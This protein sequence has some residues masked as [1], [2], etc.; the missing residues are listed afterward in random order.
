MGF[1][2]TD[3]P[4]A[5]LP[6]GVGLRRATALGHLIDWRQTTAP[7]ATWGFWLNPGSFGVTEGTDPW[8]SQERGHVSGQKIMRICVAKVTLYFRK[9]L[10]EHLLT[11]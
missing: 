10:G 8:R 7:S 5:V 2:G 9:A 4:A 6:P 1:L 11:P 3:V